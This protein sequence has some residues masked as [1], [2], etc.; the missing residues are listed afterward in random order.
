MLHN[1]CAT[2]EEEE[3]DTT[4]EISMTSRVLMYKKTNYMP[5]TNAERGDEDEDEG[6]ERVL[7]AA[8]ARVQEGARKRDTLDALVAARYEQA[9]TLDDEAPQTS[10]I[11]QS[12]QNAATYGCTMH[13]ETISPIHIP[14]QIKQ[15]D[16]IS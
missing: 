8:V 1:G 5:R 2:Q 15:N 16:L 6:E 10:L 11:Q 3:K 9:R 4:K 7:D 14:T 12:T 13:Q